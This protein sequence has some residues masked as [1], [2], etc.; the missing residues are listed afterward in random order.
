MRHVSLLHSGETEMSDFTTFAKR[1]QDVLLDACRTPHWTPQEAE[2][3]MTD[4]AERRRRFEE[5]AQ[6]LNMDVIRPRLET[7]ASYFTNSSV[8][9]EEQPNRS[10]CWFGFCQRFPA[11]TQLEFAVEHDVRFEK[12]IVHTRTRMMPAFVRFCEQD[13]LP[14]PLDIVA[15]DQV[16]DWVEERLLEFL[17]TYLRIDGGGEEFAEEPATDP[18]CGMQ[19][20]RS[21]AAA[22]DSYYGHPYFFCCEECRVKFQQDPAQ[23]VQ[24]KTI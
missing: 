2:T 6:H 21:T 11:T 19:I 4:Y 24:V 13:R 20:L 8:Q 17:D 5:L 7:V 3:Y 23:Y 1:V 16:A 12:L 10:S 22:S 14:V 18:V 9:E 15:D